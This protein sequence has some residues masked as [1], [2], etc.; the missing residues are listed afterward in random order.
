MK[1]G[2]ETVTKLC[3]LYS[4]RVENKIFDCQEKLPLKGQAATEKNPNKSIKRNK[5]LSIPIPG[6]PLHI[7]DQHRSIVAALVYTLNR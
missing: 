7:S 4:G 1:T 2:R 6:W 5:Q 3:L